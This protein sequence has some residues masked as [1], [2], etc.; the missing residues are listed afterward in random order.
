MDQADAPDILETLYTMRRALAE[1][2]SLI[3]HAAIADARETRGA[4][5]ALKAA[6]RRLTAPTA[7]PPTSPAIVA[8]WRHEMR[9]VVSAMVGWGHVL[10]LRAKDEATRFRA[11]EAIERNAKQL[12]GHPLDLG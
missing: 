2:A 1:A 12:R 11:L 9:G 6:Q 4:Q 10:A 3:R 8:V 5:G 7:R